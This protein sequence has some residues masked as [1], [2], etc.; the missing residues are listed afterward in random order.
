MQ[1]GF[2]ELGR[3]LQLG[4]VF[5]CVGD[6]VSPRIVR[7]TEGRGVKG[8]F[9][10]GLDELGRICELAAVLQQGF[11]GGWFLFAWGDVVPLR[12]VRATE[13]LGVRGTFQQGVNELSR[14]FELA[15]V[16]L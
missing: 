16:L 7:A 11:D 8:I 13:D 2:D 3:G 10:Q 12:I 9:Q 15:T 1:Q 6:V 4:E 5:V 14:I